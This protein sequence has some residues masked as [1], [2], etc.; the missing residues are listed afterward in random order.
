MKRLH[1]LIALCALPYLTCSADNTD[2]TVVIPPSCLDGIKKMKMRATSVRRDARP[3][4]MGRRACPLQTVS[5]A[6]VAAV[7]A[8]LQAVQMVSKTVQKSLWTVAVVAV[9]VTQGKSCTDAAQRKSGVCQS[10]SCRAACTDN[11]KTATSWMSTVAELRKVRIWQDV[12]RQ[13]RLRKRVC[14]AGNVCRAPI[15]CLELLTVQPGTPSGVYRIDPDGAGNRQ[16]GLC[17]SM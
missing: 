11:V 13:R 5:P 15:S 17:C 16:A 1:A 6:S 10:G 4:Q 12:H 7:A 14:G 2:N 9:C 8:K 3:V